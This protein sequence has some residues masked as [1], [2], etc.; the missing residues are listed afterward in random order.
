MLQCV[1]VH[2]DAS[3]IHTVT[4]LTTPAGW[5]HAIQQSC[6]RAVQ[7]VGHVVPEATANAYL[8]NSLV[9]TITKP[10]CLRIVVKKFSITIWSDIKIVVVPRSVE[11]QSNL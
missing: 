8:V 6:R 4:S 10:H 2:E 11:T 1:V 7:E 5:V 9:N 3:Y